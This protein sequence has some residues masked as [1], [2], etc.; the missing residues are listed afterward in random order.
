MARKLPRHAGDSA[1]E[2]PESKELSVS[3][4][5]K[6][7]LSAQAKAAKLGPDGRTMTDPSWVFTLVAHGYLKP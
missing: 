7:L 3:A 5:R 2:G 4:L 1:G 6:S